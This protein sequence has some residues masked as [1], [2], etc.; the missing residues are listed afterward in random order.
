APNVGIFPM[1]S[2]GILLVVPAIRWR[3]SQSASVTKESFDR[4]DEGSPDTYH[5]ADCLRKRDIIGNA[6]P[7]HAQRVCASRNKA[8]LSGGCNRKAEVLQKLR[9]AAVYVPCGIGK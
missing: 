6:E 9:F 8:R 5:R 3:R 2:E 7:W 1:E 4:V